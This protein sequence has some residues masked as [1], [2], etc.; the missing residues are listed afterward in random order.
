MVPL[1]EIEPKSANMRKKKRKLK[2]VLLTPTA[3]HFLKEMYQT[4]LQ[5]QKKNLDK[6]NP[7]KPM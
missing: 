2:L 5:I 1:N 3:A 6:R 7:L 4:L